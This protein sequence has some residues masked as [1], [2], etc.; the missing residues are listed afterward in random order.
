MHGGIDRQ[1]QNVN[2]YRIETHSNKWSWQFISCGID[3]CIQNAW[4]VYRKNHPGWSLLDFRRYF[5]KSLLET[6]RTRKYSVNNTSLQRR[7]TR[8][9]RLSN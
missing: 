9:S 8:E 2:I 1:D 6:N 7:P 3:I 4:I 5:A